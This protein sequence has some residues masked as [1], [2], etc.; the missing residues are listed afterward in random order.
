M[1]NAAQTY[2][3]LS[4]TGASPVGLV[5]ALYDNAVKSLHRAR[6]AMEANNIEQRTQWLNH[7]LS[8]ITHLQGTLDMEAGGEV[9]RT[10]MQ[11]YTYASARV[12]DISL[13]KS[14]DKLVE[15]ASQ[16]AS[17]RE[18]W[19]IVDAQVTEGMGVEVGAV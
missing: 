12:L 9:A 6:R 14:T 2:T 13:T 7:T 16:F 8:I 5:V 11:F 15:L 4:L 1:I 18:A 19:Q 10:L 17:L 3:S